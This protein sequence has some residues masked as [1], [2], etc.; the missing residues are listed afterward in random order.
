VYYVIGSRKTGRHQ[1]LIALYNFGIASC[2]VGSNISLHNIL[3]NYEIEE[4][5]GC[6]H[7][8]TADKTSCRLSTTPQWRSGGVELKLHAC[9]ITGA[10]LKCIDRPARASVA[11]EKRTL[12][13]VCCCS[14]LGGNG[15]VVVRSTPDLL[16]IRRLFVWELVDIVLSQRELSL[17]QVGHVITVI[18]G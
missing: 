14:R 9:L 11:R 10:E 17:R 12:V 13:L 18:G 6:E 2:Q 16:G 4:G 8:K 1:L 3:K 5:I 15:T 7:V